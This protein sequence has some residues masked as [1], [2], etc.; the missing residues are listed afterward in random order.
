MK[1]PEA[2]QAVGIVVA[3]RDPLPSLAGALMRTLRK[4][5]IERELKK[6]IPG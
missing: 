3:N 1:K 6:L 2:T 4:T 5:D